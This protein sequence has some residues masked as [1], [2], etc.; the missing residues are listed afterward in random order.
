MEGVVIVSWESS[1]WVARKEDSTV[2][3]TTGSVASI[4]QT[5]INYASSGGW[6]LRLVSSQGRPFSISNTT[7][8]FPTAYSNYVDASGCWFVF[9]NGSLP[10]I[11]FDTQAFGTHRFTGG[12]IRYTGT[13]PVV[14]MRPESS[15]ALGL[16]ITVI[17]S[18]GHHYDLGTILTVG[19]T[20]SA[21]LLIDVTQEADGNS[22]QRL[23][24]GFV[25]NHVR[26]CAE[27]WGQG[28]IGIHY[29]SPTDANQ[30]GGE[31]TFEFSNIEG[32]TQVCIKVGDGGEFDSNLGTNI[33]RGNLAG[34]PGACLETYAPWDQ[35][36]L[37]SAN[38]YAPGTYS[39]YAI[40]FRA[41]ARGNVLVT[42]Q[43]IPG[44]TGAIL[45]QGSTSSEPNQINVLTYTPP[46]NLETTAGTPTG[47]IYAGVFTYVD[48]SWTINNGSTVGL[49]WLYSTAAATF[50]LKIIRRNSAGN[51][52]VVASASITHGGAGWQSVSITPYTVPS[53]GK[54]YYVG[55][56]V[57]GTT[58]A[59]I[60][61]KDRAYTSANATG[62]S[63]TMTEQTHS[64][65]DYLVLP[66]GVTYQ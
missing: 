6:P 21:A 18:Q 4:L 49:L 29:L 66:V 10:G 43:I 41:N 30:T 11:V 20:P 47:S 24:S 60:D 58:H 34:G 7:I 51:Y 22:N 59:M 37:H 64:G 62:S 38:I 48:R 33:W 28:Q 8:T 1:A 19:G 56:Y 36:Y 50:P 57:N 25:C 39:D 55:V 40:K 52:D 46:S 45:D 27:G 61:G 5:A 14:V 44:S 15:Y 54:E 53:D 32:M 63:V 9:D 12:Q 2:L 16:G 26:L 31:N 17:W 3:S 13:G 23:T 42:K 35:W 65:A